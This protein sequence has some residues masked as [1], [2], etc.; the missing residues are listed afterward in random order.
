M[1]MIHDSR[2]YTRKQD[3]LSIV[4]CLLGHDEMLI[5]AQDHIGAT[6]M[7]YACAS[8]H[9]DLIE[10]L[11]NAPRGDDVVVDNSDRTPLF[12]AAEH[13]RTEVV[14]AMSL[15]L[16]A[17]SKPK[18]TA[19]ASR[20]LFSDFDRLNLPKHKDNRGWLPLHAA[21]AAGKSETVKV[22]LERLDIDPETADEEGRTP[23]CLADLNN[24]FDCRALLRTAIAARSHALGTKDPIQE[25]S[26]TSSG[27]PVGSILVAA[28]SLLVLLLLNW[29]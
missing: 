26:L 7:H 13:G 1:R 27:F 18:N 11:L 17:A 24:H 19:V 28:I 21:A 14:K 4:R 16:S 9:L 29:W 15:Q 23:L 3:H 12:W 8:G 2:Q 6:A 25:E 22:L 10:L 20:Y 5:H